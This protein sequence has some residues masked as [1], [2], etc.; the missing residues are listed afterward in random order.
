V[1]QQNEWIATGSDD[2][3]L[4]EMA[5]PIRSARLFELS[6]QLRYGTPTKEDLLLAASVLHAYARLQC[7]SG[8]RAM[9]ILAAL[10]RVFRQRTPPTKEGGGDV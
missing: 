7:M 9:K 6:W 1:T 4:S 3:T 5:W 2:L 10:R 8:K